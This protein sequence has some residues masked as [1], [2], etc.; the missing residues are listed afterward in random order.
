MLNSQE[1]YNNDDNR[2]QIYEDIM[3]MDLEEFNANLSE[4][5]SMRPQ[6]E[7]D[8]YSEY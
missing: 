7:D 5:S 3:D 6:L 2:A 8:Q 4:W 1:N